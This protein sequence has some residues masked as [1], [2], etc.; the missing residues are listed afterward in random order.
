MSALHWRLANYLEQ[1]QITAYAL[2]KAM[3]ASYMNTVY[4]MAKKGKEPSRVDLPTLLR[5]LDGLRKLT[6]EDV[7]L[8]DIL[9]YVPDP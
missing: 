7:Q 9:E 1:R 8:S 5:I 2:G 6:G 3:G 4:K